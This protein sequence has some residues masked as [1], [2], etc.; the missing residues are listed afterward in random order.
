MGLICFWCKEI[1]EG[2][3]SITFLVTSDS[4]SSLLPDAA[5]QSARDIPFVT[6]YILDSAL[7]QLRSKS[8]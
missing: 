5:E 2:V 7:N 6:K 1:L 8:F 4:S 3:G